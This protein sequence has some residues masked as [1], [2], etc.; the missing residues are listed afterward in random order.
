MV[1]ELIRRRGTVWLV[2]VLGVMLLSGCG[3]GE[4]ESVE[5]TFTLPRTYVDLDL[6]TPEGAVAEFVSA[7]VRRDYGTAG[8]I[9]HRDTQATM[10]AAFATADLSAVTAPE[11]QASV[12]ALFARRQ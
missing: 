5:P 7:F 2:A 4:T 9:P 11:I 6:A 3:G 12:L 1:R 8:L 10:E